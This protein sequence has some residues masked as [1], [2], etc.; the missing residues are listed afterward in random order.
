VETGYFVVDMEEGIGE[1]WST[2]E[3]RICTERA[4]EE[5]Y[6]DGNIN[7]KGRCVGVQPIVSLCVCLL[8]FGENRTKLKMQ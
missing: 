1:I 8:S 6:I 5:V 7:V 2:K 3:E 4:W